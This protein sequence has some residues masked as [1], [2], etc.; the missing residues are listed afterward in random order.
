MMTIIFLLVVVLVGFILFRVETNKEIKHHYINPN[1]FNNEYCVKTPVECQSDEDCSK[2]K[3]T[4]KLT[5]QVHNKRKYCLPLK[6]DRP[7]EPKYGGIWTWTGWTNPQLQEWDCLCLHPEI[8]GIEG[9][10]QLNPDV[11]KN[12]V[13]TYNAETM[14]RRPLPSDCKCNENQV[15][16]VSNNIPKC[17][18]KNEGYCPNAHVCELFYSG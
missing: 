3:D 16:I 17:I 10:T 11:C 6:P 14:K 7:C 2:C 18:T 5:C 13:Y 12:G 9:C 4:I 15:K 1:V 8:S